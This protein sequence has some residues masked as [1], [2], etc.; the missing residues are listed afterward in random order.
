MRVGV[1]GLG[2]I[3][4][5]VAENLVADGHDVTV[6]DLDDERV[7]SLSD[8]G[9]HGAATVGGVGAVAEI[10]MLSLPTPAVVGAVAEQWAA[11]AASGSILVDLSTNDPAI[12]RD[13]GERLA[14]S[15]HR[16]VEAPLTGGAI[17]AKKRMLVFMI[18]GDDEAV[19]RVRPVLDPLGR[20][21]FHLG[22]LGLGNTMK[23]VNSLIAFSTTW[24]TLEGLSLALKAGIPVA[25]AADVLRTGGAT[26]FYLE[27]QVET[28]GDRG[29]AAAFA[30]DLAAKDA[31]LIVDTAQALGVPTPVGSAV[32]QILLDAIAAGF[33]PA[34]WSELAGVA[35]HAAGIEL[36]WE[37][38]SD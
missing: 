8:G 17:G 26:N 21:T 27:R 31:G 14:G 22:P 1:I 4:R 32:R 20:A 28:I 35:E 25:T 6:F 33:G 23:L 5:P 3:G 38:R 11:A 13:L 16:L 18:G 9:A 34:D 30:L 2:N 37:P 24:V 19:A 7:A 29:N 10:T 15:D 12:V 36:R